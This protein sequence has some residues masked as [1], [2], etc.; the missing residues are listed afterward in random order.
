MTSKSIKGQSPAALQLALQESM[1]DGFAPTLAIVFISVKQDRKAIAALLTEKGIAIFGATSAGEFIDGHESQGEMA[2]LLLQIDIGLYT[3]SFYETK[4]K[5]VA[6]V[7]KEAARKALRTFANPAFILCTTCLS[8][9]GEMYDGGTVIHSIQDTTG[10][11]AS[12]FGAMSGDDGLLKGT[13]V[14]SA[15]QS[16]DEGFVML[17]LDNDAIDLYGMAISGWKPMGKVRTVTKAEDG[18]MYELDGQPALDMYLRYLGQSLRTGEDVER[19]LF[20][21]DIG[22]F[23]PFLSVDAGEPSLRTPLE[24]SKE[25]KAIKLD[26]PLAEGKQLQFTVPPDFDIVETVLDSAT[27]LKE[28]EK[29]AADAVLIFS[30]LGRRSALGPMVTDEN[31]GLHKIWNAPMAGFFSYGEYGND[32]GS[33][34]VFHSTTCSWVALKE[35]ILP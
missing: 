28:K 18:W 32:P 12:I 2:I 8:E 23:Y 16:T 9:T 7:A 10:K 3:L 6:V 35:K 20:V 1:A 27:A 29:A 17:V 26:I 11:Q 34:H 33:D 31:Q 13:Y 19:V 4:N 22:F 15:N 25:R 5:D 24:V 14:F 21:E 30:C